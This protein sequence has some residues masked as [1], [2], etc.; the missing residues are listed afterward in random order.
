MIYVLRIVRKNC[1]ETIVREVFIG[2]SL[3]AERRLG[4]LWNKHAAHD[5]NDRFRATMAD[6]KTCRVLHSIN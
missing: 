1:R 4:D 2:S 5:G 3:D 6:Y